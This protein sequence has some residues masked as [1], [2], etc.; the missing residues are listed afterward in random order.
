MA[1]PR[2][3]HTNAISPP[4]SPKHHTRRKSGQ[5]HTTK[6]KTNRPALSRR[7]TT[8]THTHIKSSSKTS[9]PTTRTEE[10]FEF[11]DSEESESFFNFCTSCDKQLPADCGNFLYCSEK[12]RLN[13]LPTSTQKYQFPASPPL[14]PF[15]M[16]FPV[17]HER[18]RSEGRDIIPRFTPSPYNDPALLS[19]NSTSAV[20]SLRSLSR[21]LESTGRTPS[22]TNFSKPASRP[23]LPR[24]PSFSSSESEGDSEDEEEYRRLHRRV[25]STP[26]PGAAIYGTYLK[27]SPSTYTDNLPLPRKG[28]GETY[29][30]RSVDLVT[31]VVS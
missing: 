1:P 7:Q 22:S 15:A 18:K 3:H 30:P 25:P 26:H 9:V 16:T 17:L 27:P 21:A 24:R 23:T 19:P 10:C 28:S 2:P 29:K 6:S 12:C 31:P 4:P 8:H 14:T 20:D 13:D 11:D 5:T